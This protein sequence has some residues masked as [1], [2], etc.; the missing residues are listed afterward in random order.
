METGM[1][2]VPGPSPE[3]AERDLGARREASTLQCRVGLE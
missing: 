3:R 1:P 2:S